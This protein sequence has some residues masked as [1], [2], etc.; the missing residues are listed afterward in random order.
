[1]DDIYQISTTYWG[2]GDK[3]YLSPAEEPKGKIIEME[4]VEILIYVDH[5]RKKIV[6][7]DAG[8]KKK[9]GES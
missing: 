2:V 7:S 1:M 9:G 3:F 5:N 6:I 4:G 8:I